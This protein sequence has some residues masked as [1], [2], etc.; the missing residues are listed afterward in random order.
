MLSAV[1]PEARSATLV[2]RLLMPDAWRRS[3]AARHLIRDAR[4]MKSLDF[5]S[6]LVQKEFEQTSEQPSIK[7]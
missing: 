4:R 1:N 3:S 7:G 2:V 5:V 6:V